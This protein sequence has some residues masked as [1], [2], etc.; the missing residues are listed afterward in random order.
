MSKT[1]NLASKA[2][3]ASPEATLE[4]AAPPNQRLHFEN[5]DEISG[6][7][8]L[9]VPSEIQHQ[10]IRVILRGVISNK[11]SDVYYGAIG[12]MLKAGAQYEFIQ[13]TRDMDGPGILKQ[14]TFDY[15]FNFKNVDLDVDSYSGIVLDVRFEVSAEMVYQGSMMSYT[16]KDTR[17]FKVRNS[18]KPEEV[19]DSTTAENATEV[20]AVVPKQGIPCPRLAIEFCGFRATEKPCKIEVYLHN[21]YLHIDRD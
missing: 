7:L 10:G 6:A 16:V 17:I 18:K 19:K 4:L 11:S 13:L 5:G 20:A 1:A 14:G 21:S 8:S 15:R 2:V 12:G 3:G 9:E